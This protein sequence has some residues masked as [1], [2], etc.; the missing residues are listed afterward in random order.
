MQILEIFLKIFKKNWRNSFIGIEI[1]SNGYGTVEFEES[2]IIGNQEYIYWML[3][4]ID[5]FTRE[6]R[7]FCVLENRNKE[8]IIPII[9]DNFLT[10]NI[11][12]MKLQKQE[13]IRFF[14]SYQPREF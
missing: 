13:F 5:K 2:E 6:A 12:L 14:P 4:L 9:K 10:N 11:K 3:G 7:V 1:G 8:N